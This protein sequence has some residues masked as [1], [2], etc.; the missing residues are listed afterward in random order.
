[1]PPSELRLEITMAFKL[2]NAWQPNV[3]GKCGREP[4]PEP[5]IPAWAKKP[6]GKRH[7]GDITR[8]VE[9]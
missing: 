3:G 5:G 7:V 1:M 6:E 9:Y 4:L 8:T 2:M